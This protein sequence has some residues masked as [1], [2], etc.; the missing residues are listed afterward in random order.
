M[1]NFNR[2]P[3]RESLRCLVAAGLLLCI[4]ATQHPLP[5]SQRP[6]KAWFEAKGICTF[7]LGKVGLPKTGDEIAASLTE[8]FKRVLTLP[9]ATKTLATLDGLEFPVLHSL[10]INLTDTQGDT[11]RKSPKLSKKTDPQPGLDVARLVIQ[12][13]PFVYEAAKINLD[14]IASDAKL[15]LQPDRKGNQ[16]LFLADVKEGKLTCDISV[17]D[18][19]ALLLAVAQNAGKE[20]GIEVRRATIKVAVPEPRSLSA[21]ISCVVHKGLITETVHMKGTLV[22]DDELNAKASGLKVS[23]DGPVSAVIIGLMARS[24]EKYEDKKMPL[25]SFPSRN[26]KLKDIQFK[27]DDSLHL[28]ASFGT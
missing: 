28:T 8:G 15:S 9:D 19:E 22:I 6:V 7:P 12:G 14:L 26:V 13:H 20:N 23:G 17:A 4:G 11:E 16:V 10:L 3:L 24:I 2:L 1:R 5:A 25:V 27:A 21:D 18:I